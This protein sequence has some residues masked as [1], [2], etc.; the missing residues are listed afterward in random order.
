VGSNVGFDLS[1]PTTNTRGPI[2]CILAISEEIDIAEIA[3]FLEKWGF[4]GEIP[5]FL[6]LFATLLIYRVNQVNQVIKKPIKERVVRK[7][8]TEKR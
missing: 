6:P 3:K 5:A 8:R 7:R 1:D 2:T 4:A